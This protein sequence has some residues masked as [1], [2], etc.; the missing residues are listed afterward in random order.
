MYRSAIDGGRAAEA[1]D[2]TEIG[3]AVVIRRSAANMS[4]P[5]DP[6]AQQAMRARRPKR[7]RTAPTCKSA[8]L[9]ALVA[10]GARDAMAQSCISLSGSTQC[11]AFNAS[12]ISTDSTLTGLF[13]FLSSVT[14][15]ASFDSG[16]QSYVAGGFSQERYVLNNDCIWLPYADFCT[17]MGLSSDA[18]RLMHPTLRTITHG[19]RRACC[20]ML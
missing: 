9:Y 6:E 15:T 2:G 5:R 11:S 14:D 3:Q 16:I 20:A 17:D 4:V 18:Q 1:D 8:F 10:Y 7:R 12:S 13:P 19:I